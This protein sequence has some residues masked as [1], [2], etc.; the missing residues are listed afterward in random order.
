CSECLKLVDRA[1][2]SV[3]DDDLEACLD[4]PARH[5]LAHHAEADHGQPL[6]AAHADTP[7]AGTDVISESVWRSRSRASGER[8]PTG[9]RHGPTGSPTMASA[10][11]T[12]TGNVPSSNAPRRRASRACTVRAVSIAPS[13]AAS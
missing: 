6:V 12:T 7:V 9:A 1:A 13:T 11:L 3:V 2:A 10:S 8:R 4:E 5:R